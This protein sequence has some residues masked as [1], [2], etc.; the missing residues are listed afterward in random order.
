LDLGHKPIRKS[1]DA[2]GFM[3][4]GRIAGSPGEV[5]SLFDMFPFSPD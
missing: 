3:Q 1:C 4:K 5:G 2:D